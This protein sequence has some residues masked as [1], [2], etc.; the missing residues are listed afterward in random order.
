MKIE[1]IGI[2]TR[3]RLLNWEIMSLSQLRFTDLY[4]P[5]I[6]SNKLIIMI[7]ELLFN[8]FVIQLL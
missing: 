8:I 7:C 1:I 2:V 6:I 3:H 5:P 4:K